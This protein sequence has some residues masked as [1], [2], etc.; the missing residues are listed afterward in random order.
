MLHVLSLCRKISPAERSPGLRGLGVQI[1]VWMKRDDVEAEIKRLKEHV[2]QCCSKFTAFSAARIEMTA[3]HI[4]MTTARIEDHAVNTT[5]RVEQTL[6]SNNVENQVRLRRLEGMM[7]RVLLETQF[8]QNIMNQTI[9]I[10][11]SDVTHKTLE[12]QYLSTQALRLIDRLQQLVVN[13]TLILDAPLWDV[14]L[15]L[16]IYNSPEHILYNIL[17]LLLTTNGC[18][19]EIEF[20]TIHSILGLANDLG[21]LQMKSE[22]IAWHL[23]TIQILR[24]LAGASHTDILLQL[25][26]TLHNLACEYRSQLHRDL[27]TQSSQQS[28]DLCRGLCEISTD[29]DYQPLLLTTL[30]TYSDNLREAGQPEV[31][32]STAQEAV[33]MCRPMVG[34]IIES[35]LGLA[36]WTEEIECKAVRS[37]EALFT[38]ARALSSVDRKLEA[39]ESWKEGFQIVLRFSGTRNPQLRQHIDLFLDQMCKLAEA[40]EFSLTMLSDCMILVCDLARMSPGDFSLQFLR[41]LY[42]YVYLQQESD[43]PDSGSLLKN[44]RIFLEPNSQSPIPVLKTP[45][46]FTL[47]IDCEGS[48]IEDAIWAFYFSPWTQA[49]SPL[50]KGIFIGHFDQAATTLQEVI[51][52][53]IQNPSSDSATLDWALEHISYDILPVVPH[54]K[55]VIL[56]AR[57]ADIVGHFR[58]ITKSSETTSERRGFSNTLAYHFWGLWFAGL[59]DDA[60][61]VSDEALKYL[62]PTLDTDEGNSSMLDELRYWHVFRTFVFFD[63]GRIDQAIQAMHKAKTVYPDLEQMEDYFL[64]FCMIQTYILQ[65]TARHQEALQMLQRRIPILKAGKEK[66]EL[67]WHILLVELAAVQGHTGQLGKAVKDAEKAVSACRKD[68]ANV[69]DQ[70]FA[71]VH[72]LTTLSNCLAAVGRNTEALMVA[73]EATSIYNLNASDMWRG[74]VCPFR[75]QGLGAKTLFS[76]SLRLASL[77]QLEEALANSKKATELF[78]EWVSLVPGNLPSLASNLQNQASILWNI[79][80]QD[81]A[82]SACKEA[83]TIMQQLAENETYFLADLAAGLVQLALYLSDVGDNDGASA[84]T[85]ECEEVR[86]K[87]VLLPPQPDFL[88]EEVVQ[89]PEDETYEPEEILE[90]TVFLALAEIEIVGTTDSTVSEAATVLVSL[91]P[92]LTAQEPQAPVPEEHTPKTDNSGKGRLADLLTDVKIKPNSTP[93]DALWWILLG[94]LFTVVWIRK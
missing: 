46:N 29:V 38:F 6:I 90:D 49:L 61:V 62:R 34:Q 25:A 89:E 63:M 75:K 84:A 18:P 32:L 91:D 9:E 43:S 4:E 68:M 30:V 45:S 56:L 35:G 71:L 57:M 77:G 51:S 58:G 55:Q 26:I 48:I 92:T 72:S 74:F 81:K 41:L 85:A 54:P 76:L 64:S 94:V 33:T 23:M 1:K 82:I 50:I 93:M 80:C 11:A 3:A 36:S 5:L 15:R 12:F 39:Y 42:A 65:H 16:P 69:E 22:A 70:K 28:V 31:A 20:S 73:T 88:F 87:I 59:S 27:A 79:C 52:S 86:K 53:M 21:H 19:A 2:N 24:Q 66:D 37:F 60:L 40:E 83:V 13:H 67:T 17:G 44:L 47:N 10:I 78:R 7:A 14:P 8:G